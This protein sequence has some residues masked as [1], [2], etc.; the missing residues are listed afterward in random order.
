MGGGVAIGATANLPMSPFTALLIGCIAG[1][2]SCAGF[3][4]QD[5]LIPSKY[6]TCGINNLHGMPGILG[7]LISVVLPFV[8]PGTDV[9][10]RNQLLGLLATLMVATVTGW[11]TGLVL[12]IM[13]GS[14][15]RP[16]DDGEMWDCADDKPI[17]DDELPA[18][19]LIAPAFVNCAV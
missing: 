12:R 14:P 5:H 18:A 1:T 4:F 15:G 7:G 6:D 16:Y 2:L 9:D 3:V 13:G 8:I 11:A 10:P 17:A 19:A